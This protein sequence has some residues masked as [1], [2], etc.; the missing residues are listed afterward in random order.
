LQ[1][2]GHPGPIETAATHVLADDFAFGASGSLY[3][4]THPEQTVFRLDAA[5]NRTTVAG[6]KQGAVG[7]T[8][9]AFGRAPGDENGLYVTTD[10]GLVAPY[11]GA[12]QEAKLLRLEVGEVGW[13]LIEHRPELDSRRASCRIAP[14]GC[15]TALVSRGAD[16][17]D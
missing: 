12:V 6:P 1:P 10:G 7:T 9:C 5:G 4:A 14:S 16:F 8:A 3:I 15:R 2:D 13:P 11:E 17:W